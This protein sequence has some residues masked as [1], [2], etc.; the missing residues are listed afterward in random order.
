MQSKLFLIK[1]LVK[2]ISIYLSIL[3]NRSL[4]LSLNQLFKFFQRT[5]KKTK[6]REEKIVNMSFLWK[7]QTTI[8]VL[9]DLIALRTDRSRI[10]IREIQ[11]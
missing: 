6:I 2:Y 9:H 8:F 1:Y 7:L 11:K 5:V 3:H 4:P 10:E